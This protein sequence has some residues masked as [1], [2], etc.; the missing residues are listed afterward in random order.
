MPHEKRNK[1]II[2]LELTNNARRLMNNGCNE[3][4]KIS[5]LHIFTTNSNLGIY[6]NHASFQGNLIQLKQLNARSL[7]IN[8]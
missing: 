2:F 3:K 4:L 1:P 6:C 8:H 7:K 5:I